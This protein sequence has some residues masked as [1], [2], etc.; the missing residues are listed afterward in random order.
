MQQTFHHLLMKTYFRLHRKVMAEAQ[1]I[2][3]TTGQP[4]VLECLSEEDGIDQ[5]TVASRCQIEPATA[6]SLLLRMEEAGL[7]MRRR[8]EGNRRSLIVRLTPKGRERAE[9]IRAIFLAAEERALRRLTQS[10]RSELRR[11]LARAC[12]DMNGEDVQ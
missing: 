6:G 10:E 11:M 12:E 1:K 8:E 5:A 9:Q 2:G 3:L 4:K 7:I